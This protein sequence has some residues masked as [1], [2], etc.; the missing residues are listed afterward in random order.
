MSWRVTLDC[1]K[2]EAEAIPDNEQLFPDAESPPVLV[3]QEPDETRP[4]EWRIHAYF[5]H[6]PDWE[7]MR[8]LEA[9]A[10]DADP[11]L[12]RLDDHHVLE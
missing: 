9:L 6:Q 8:A 12:E 11:V 2:A 3:A 5:D 10:A 4:D 1:S 7:D